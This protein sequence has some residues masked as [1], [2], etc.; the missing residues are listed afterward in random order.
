MQGGATCGEQ[1]TCAQVTYK[2][3]DML[4][5]RLLLR[6]AALLPPPLLPSLLLLLLLVP[7]LPLVAVLAG[8][9]SQTPS[10]T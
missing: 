2:L 1:I 6:L 8:N 7:L 5:S 10:F 3:L 4:L 9:S